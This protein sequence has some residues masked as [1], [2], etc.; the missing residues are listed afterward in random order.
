M[1]IAICNINYKTNKMTYSG[2]N[3]PLIIIRNGEILETKANKQPIGEF[4]NRVPFTTHE[5][6]LKIG[7]C[8]YIYSDGY[9]DQFGGEKGKKF[10]GKALKSLL[11]ELSGF[12]MQTQLKKLNEAFEKWKGDF[13]Q[14]DDVCLFGV[15]IKE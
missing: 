9:A 12:D 11:L 14:L 13:E 7:D 2:A 15:K 6:D 10:K 1:D 8:V 3:N 4:Q 5:F